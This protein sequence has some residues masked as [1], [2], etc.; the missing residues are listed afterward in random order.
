MSGEIVL[1]RNDNDGD[2]N[3]D[4][5]EDE[6]EDD[7]FSYLLS[8]SSSSSHYHSKLLYNLS[9]FKRSKKK[10]N[11][12]SAISRLNC[13]SS[14]SEE[15]SNLVVVVAPPP[16]WARSSR[17]TCNNRKEVVDHL[18]HANTLR[19]SAKHRRILMNLIKKVNQL[20]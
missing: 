17:T 6:D 18:Y 12:H 3:N 20:I 7:V 9:T 16:L 14:T 19:M 10:R 8:S 11:L 5:N 1:S 2:G 4:E 13:S 15:K